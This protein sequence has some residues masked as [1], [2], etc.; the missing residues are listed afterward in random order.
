MC[1]MSNL[2]RLSNAKSRS[3]CGEN[4]SGAKSGGA[5]E[6]PP[7]DENGNPTGCARDLG[8]G[9]KVHPCD[10]IKIGETFV[11]ADIEGSGCIQHI[12][13]TPTGDYRT[14]ILRIY[15]DG[16]DIPAVE[17]PIGDFFASAFTSYSTYANISSQAVC[18]NPGN[19]FNC[20]WPMPFKK[21]ILITLENVSELEIKGIFYQIDYAL[22]D[23][24]EDTAYFHAQFRRVNPLK[25]GDVYTIADNIK[26]KGHYVGT[27]LAWQIN[28][29]GWWGEGEIKFYMDGDCDPALSDGKEVAGSTGF[30]TICGTG[31]EDYFCGSYN[32]ENK[33]TK[34]Y[35][36]YTNAYAGVPHI[37]RP[38][39]GNMYDA[40]LRFSMYRWHI[41]D[42]I[43]FEKDLK[44]TIQ[45]MGWQRGGRYLPLQDDIAS[46]AFWYQIG[47]TEPFPE[48]PCADDL[49]IN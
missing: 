1:N 42:P 9:W 8:Q 3:I 20:Y 48:L 33:A 45:A 19:A 28:N 26:G 23:V 14:T 25:K 46:V 21:R 35:Q 34:E 49:M 11:L 39:S 17:C 40:N 15:Y 7:V 10:D 2:A 5:R 31:T 36:E 22:N 4:R 37:M 30:P 13:M 38:N 18:V 44:V 27:Y 24:P 12:W 29:N 41:T 32:F 6:F 43:R 16:S 47:Q